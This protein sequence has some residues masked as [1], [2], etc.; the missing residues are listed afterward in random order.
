MTY[1]ID[2][3][4]SLPD[5]VCFSQDDPFYHCPNF[6][7]RVNQFNGEK[8]FHP[9]GITYNREGEDIL[10]KTKKYADS[11]GIEYNEPIKFINSAQCIVSKDL[12]K[13][14]PKEFYQRI[15]NS[16]SPNQI[17][18]ET[19]YFIEYLWPTILSFNNQLEI[20]RTNC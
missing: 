5:F 9:L 7:N 19:N 17:I 14:K 16:L 6:L 11:V 2:H 10:N 13:L 12:I 3:Y 4:D 20:S 1:I 15:K 8:M 18:T